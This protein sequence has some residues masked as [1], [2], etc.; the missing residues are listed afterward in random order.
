MRADPLS[1]R[2]AL[3]TGAARG[4]GLAIATA[5]AREGA[6]V[7]ISDLDSGALAKAAGALVEE[8]HRVRAVAGDVSKTNDIARMVK[9]A[10]EGFGR[11]DVLVNNAGGSAHTPYKVEDV[12]EEDY[13]RVMDWNVRG[14][15]FCTQA[16]LPALKVAGGSI[17]NLA[18]LSGQMGGATWSAQYSAAKGAI[19][20][21]TRNLAKQLGP[22]GIRVNAIAPG[23]VSTG[24]RADD[25]WAARDNTMILS[26]IALGRRGD[27]SEL[28]DVALFLASDL[29]RYVSGVLI[30]VDGGFHAG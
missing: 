27:A 15:F 25:L 12:R 21:L 1:G 18:S 11:L 30:D 7:V 8:G 2:V 23:F 19:I 16:A 17:I 9:G 14:T 13:E 22:Y 28:A 4:L 24:G 6:A 10:T 29:S 5:L 26:Q 3:V 20:A